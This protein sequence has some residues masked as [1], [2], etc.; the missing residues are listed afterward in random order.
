MGKED[1]V[2][3]EAMRNLRD[4]V[5][6][7][8]SFGRRFLLGICLGLGSAIGASLIGGIVLAVIYRVFGDYWFEYFGLG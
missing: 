8:N 5:G 6:K 4:E 1:L 3:A 2:L 7:L